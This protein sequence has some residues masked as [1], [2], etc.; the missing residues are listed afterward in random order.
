MNETR[1]NSTGNTSGRRGI[2]T[3]AWKWRHFVSPK[4]L[5]CFRVRV[6]AGVSGNMLRPNVFSSKWV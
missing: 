4:S 5:L 2:C 1:K 3:F 6:R